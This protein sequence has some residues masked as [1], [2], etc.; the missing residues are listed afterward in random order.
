MKIKGKARLARRSTRYK[1][2][3]RYAEMMASELEAA[4]VPGAAAARRA[5]GPRGLEALASVSTAARP[6]TRAPLAVQMLDCSN[7]RRGS[8]ST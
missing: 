7:N 6:R 3:T 5:R 2:G 4:G 8:R 1:M